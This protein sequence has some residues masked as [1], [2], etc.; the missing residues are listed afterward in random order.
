M[1]I[2]KRAGGWYIVTAGGQLPGWQRDPQTWGPYADRPRRLS[3]HSSQRT[4]H[5]GTSKHIVSTY[6]TTTGR[7][8]VQRDCWL[9]REG[10]AQE[11]EYAW[12]DSHE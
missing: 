10:E 3:R 2:T 9:P 7:I 11:I 8:T 1:K 5:G 12:E 6:A 4:Y